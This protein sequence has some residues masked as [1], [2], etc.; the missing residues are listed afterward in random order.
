M[1]KRKY[2]EIIKEDSQTREA[3]A[4]DEINSRL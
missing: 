2:E 3:T 1:S 4:D